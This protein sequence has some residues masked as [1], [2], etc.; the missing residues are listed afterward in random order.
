MEEEHVLVGEAPE[1]TRPAEAGSVPSEGT[2]T[3]KRLS[4]E[5]ILRHRKYI[6]IPVFVP[7]IPGCPL[8][9]IRPFR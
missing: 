6:V 9:N 5:E 4:G 2:K 3:E 1:G 8:L 7:G